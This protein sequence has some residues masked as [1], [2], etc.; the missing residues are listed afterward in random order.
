MTEARHPTLPALPEDVRWALERAEGYLDL[1]MPAPARRE[2]DRVPP[3]HQDH[4]AF[5]RVRLQSLMAG[6]EWAEAAELAARL[7]QIEPG[8][9]SHLIQ[10]AFATRRAKGIEEAKALLVEGLKAFPEV[11]VIPYNLACYECQLGHVDAAMKYLDRVLAKDS[12]WRA[13]ALED[14]DLR[15][16]WPQL[17]A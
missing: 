15:S 2:L 11:D 13:V 1:K 4:P 14:A 7:R 17:E 5:L 9:P 10:Q 8:E 3:E 16:L 6:E 12:G